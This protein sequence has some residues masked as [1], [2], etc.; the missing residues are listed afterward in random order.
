M[1]LDDLKATMAPPAIPLGVE[2]RWDEIQV[3]AELTIPADFKAFVEAYGEGSI[4]G[5]LWLLHPGSANRVVEMTGVVRAIDDA[6]ATLRR[7]HPMTYL[8]P[9]L[10]E[11]GSFLPWALTDNGDYLGWLVEGCDPDAWPVAVLDD[12][13]GRPERFAMVLGV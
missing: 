10:P 6:Y 4:G 12:E 13:D 7:S 11:Q 5:F 9:S 2:A 3:E 1:W 8:L